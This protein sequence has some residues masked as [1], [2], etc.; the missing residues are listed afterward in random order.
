MKAYRISFWLTIAISN[1]SL[2]AG[3]FHA[4]YWMIVFVL[5]PISI[6]LFIFRQRSFFWMGTLFLSLN[7]LVAVIGVIIHVSFIPLIIASTISL[8]SWDLYLFRQDIDSINPDESK[9]GLI[10]D[11]LYSLGLAISSGF[12]LAVTFS[13]LEFKLPFGLIVL[14]VLIAMVCLMISV[15]TLNRNNQ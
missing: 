3:F 5:F 9:S 14:F 12:I 4:G 8:A 13:Y 2:V 6:Q 10:K 15:K 11:H 1:L 7:L